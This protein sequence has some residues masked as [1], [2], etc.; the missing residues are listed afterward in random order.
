MEQEVNI[1]KVDDPK[2]V[3]EIFKV[4]ISLMLSNYYEQ[5][6]NN[7]FPKKEDFSSIEEYETEY[8][9]AIFDLIDEIEEIKH[10]MFTGVLE[11]YNDFIIE[12][13]TFD[14]TASKENSESIELIDLTTYDMKKAGII[15]VGATILLPII[16]P[17][18][19]VFN[20]PRIGMDVLSKKY[21]EKRLEYNSYIQG[22]FK[23]IQDPFYEL[24]Y[25]LRSDYH[26]SKQELKELKERALQGEDIADDLIPMLNPERVNLPYIPGMVEI[27]KEEEKELIKKND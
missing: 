3:V 22:K 21:H 26:K 16:A 11:S 10:E 6:K 13:N 2:E 24:T 15:T 7:V 12:K 20:L 25:S 14:A 23:E 8:N 5:V 1:V 27:P 19:I 18:V 17:I 9:L 4:Q